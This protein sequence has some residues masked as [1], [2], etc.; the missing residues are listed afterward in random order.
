MKNYKPYDH[1][2][3]YKGVMLYAD[4]EYQPE[5][6]SE[7]RWLVNDVY[8]TIPLNSEIVFKKDGGD[9][10]YSIYHVLL[11]PDEVSPKEAEL[12]RGV[13][14]MTINKFNSR[15]KKLLFKLLNKMEDFH[16][17]LEQ[18]IKEY[19]EQVKADYFIDQQMWTAKH[20]YYGF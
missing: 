18:D 1:N 14:T 9:N 17:A 12:I 5:E 15:D 4:T 11:N 16:K 3:E 10:L 19:A 7:S 8:V 13:S 6:E 2:M 20:D